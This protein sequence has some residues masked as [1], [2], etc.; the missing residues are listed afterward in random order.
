[1]TVFH[2]YVLKRGSRYI[3]LYCVPTE[4]NATV[5]E[6]RFLNSENTTADPKKG[7]KL[8]AEV[9][10][11]KNLLFPYCTFVRRA[12]TLYIYIYKTAYFRLK[13]KPSILLLD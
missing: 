4:K 5:F 9:N 6:P 7:S 2:N 12:H 3:T 8:S 11:Q 13:C 10:E 1:M